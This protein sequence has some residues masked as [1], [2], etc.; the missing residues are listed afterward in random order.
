M[1]TIVAHVSFWV[2]LAFASRE[3]SRAAVLVFVLLWLL[4]F[5]GTR[6]YVGGAYLCLALVAI[7]DIGLILAIFKGDIAIR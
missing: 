3:I 5:V 7:L 2:L 6:F 4:V 1:L